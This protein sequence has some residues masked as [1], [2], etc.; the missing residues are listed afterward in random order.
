MSWFRSPIVP[1]LLLAAATV[2]CSSETNPVPAAA[3]ARPDSSGDTFVVRPTGGH[4]IMLQPIELS[5][6]PVR[7]QTPPT[8]AFRTIPPADADQVIRAFV[9][10]VVVINGARFN[11][12]NPD[13]ELKV[14]VEWGDGQRS[15]GGCGPCRVDHVYRVG[16]YELTA[17]VHD[18][19]LVDRGSVTETFTVI[20]QGPAEPASVPAG[21]APNCHTITKPN[22]A[23]PTGATTFC[24]SDPV[25]DPR[26]ATHALT[27]C[28]ACYGSGACSNFNVT[29]FG[30][31]TTSFGASV[32]LSSLN[33]GF[34]Y[35]RTSA[36]GPL[37]GEVSDFLIASCPAGGRWAR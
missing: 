15:V 30:T 25:V 19:R 6:A 12:A 9:D 21:L 14:E 4:E 33:S 28:N 37:P 36:T 35:A 13:D 16:R 31:P 20:V 17:T 2:G 10:D 8:G 26:N 29:C 22:G 27:A 7:A 24:V 11:P 18:R 3:N 34:V 23:C 32:N 1:A 5:D